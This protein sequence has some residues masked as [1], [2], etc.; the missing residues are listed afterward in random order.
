MKLGVDF[1]VLPAFFL[2]LSVSACKSAGSA[3]TAKTIGTEGMGNCSGAA[4]ILSGGMPPADGEWELVGPG[5]FAEAI[6]KAQKNGGVSTSVLSS[7]VSVSGAASSALVDDR[8]TTY[9]LKWSG[10]V[11][12]SQGNH[13][14]SGQGAAYHRGGFS[15]PI[16]NWKVIPKANPENLSAAELEHLGVSPGKR[17]D[18]IF[19]SGIRV[20]GQVEAVTRTPEGKLAIITWG[21]CTMTDVGGAVLYAPD[22]GLFDMLVG[23][24]ISS[25]HSGPADLDAYIRELPK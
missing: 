19:N 18:L 20:S 22:W 1:V 4:R 10:P 11:Q 16:G 25:I 7:G 3:S 13:Q 8:G 12:I 17:T 23:V 2:L 9:F 24:E 14:I 5:H 15:S 21:D 6:A